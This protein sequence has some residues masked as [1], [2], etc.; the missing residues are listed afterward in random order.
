MTRV[1]LIHFGMNQ[2]SLKFLLV[3]SAT[4]VDFTDCVSA[5]CGD[6]IKRCCARLYKIS[7]KQFSVNTQF[8]QSAWVTRTLVNRNLW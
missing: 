8:G 2:V 7:A 3:K 5:E 6:V 4:Q 1:N